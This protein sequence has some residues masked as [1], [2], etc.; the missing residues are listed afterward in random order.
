MNILH[1]NVV[2]N[3]QIRVGKIPD[4]LDPGGYQTVRDLRSLGLRYG[5]SRDLDLII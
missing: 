3:H 4:S 5:K 2:G 1:H